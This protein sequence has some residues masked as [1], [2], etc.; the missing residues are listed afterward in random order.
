MGEHEKTDP[1]VWVKHS[2][3]KSFAEVWGRVSGGAEGP[4]IARCGGAG[5]ERC[6]TWGSLGWCR[7][8]CPAWCTRLP[9]VFV[10]WVLDTVTC[11]QGSSLQLMFI[12]QL[13]RGFL[14]P[15]VLIKN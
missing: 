12:V 11:F 4:A 6:V 8:R 15:W 3:T 2:Q 10:L 13:Q 9:V 1:G 7:C 5:K 14:F